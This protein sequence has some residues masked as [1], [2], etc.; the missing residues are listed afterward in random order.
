MVFDMPTIFRQKLQWLDYFNVLDGESELEANPA[1]EQPCRSSLRIRSIIIFCLIIFVIS[2]TVVITEFF[3][4]SLECRLVRT[5]TSAHDQLPHCGS[6]VE[7]ARAQN[8]TF[9][10]M[11]NG[12][13]PPE[14]YS[15]RLTEEFLSLPDKR[16]H[17][18]KE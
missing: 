18:D 15:A 8:C 3:F 11:A 14:C 9:G 4:Q 1:D 2:I 17:Y 13:T 10:A 5:Q 6:S 16:W 12:W 7:E